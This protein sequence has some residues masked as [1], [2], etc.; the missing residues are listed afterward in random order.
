MR[1]IFLA[2]V[3]ICALVI[4]GISGTLAG[5]SDTESSMGNVIEVGN[6]DLKVSKGWDGLEKDDPLPIMIEAKELWPCISKDFVFDVHNAS[7]NPESAYIYLCFKNF[8]CYEVSSDKH[9][10]GRPEPEVVAEEGGWLANQN[11]PAMGEWGQCCNLSHF[12]EIAIEYD[13]DGDGDLDLVLGNPVW[14]GPGTVYLGDLWSTIVDKCCWIPLGTLPGCNTRYGKVSVHISNWSEEEWNARLGTSL[15]YFPDDIPFNDWLTNL[16]M[17]D[18]VEFE[19]S[20][21][22][23]QDEIPGKY[24]IPCLRPAL[25][26]CPSD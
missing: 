5:F 2:V 18:G 17:N 21:A 4:A 11:T 14:G 26:P 8:S 7:D 19:V 6:L 20:W 9:P 22:L 16:F 24:T 25:G 3:V 10:D 12:I 1:K 23:T 15:D 13:T